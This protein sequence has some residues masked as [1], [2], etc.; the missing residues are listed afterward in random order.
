MTQM[1]RLKWENEVLK[2]LLT[3]LTDDEIKLLKDRVWKET[4]MKMT[5]DIFSLLDKIKK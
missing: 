5:K 1:N 3:L 4:D 2:R